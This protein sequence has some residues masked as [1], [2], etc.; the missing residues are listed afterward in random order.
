MSIVP[1]LISPPP[2]PSAWTCQVCHEFPDDGVDKCGVLVL[3]VVYAEGRAGVR[4]HEGE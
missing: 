4:F 1:H 2:T 3:V